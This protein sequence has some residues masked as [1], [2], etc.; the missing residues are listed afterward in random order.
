MAS[1]NIA[2][3][4]LFTIK[5]RL[6]GK[7]Y[8]MVNKRRNTHCVVAVH[9]FGGGGNVINTNKILLRLYTHTNG[10]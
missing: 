4:E 2:A 5:Q 10:T 6:N 7:I 1:T 8:F 9:T 3:H